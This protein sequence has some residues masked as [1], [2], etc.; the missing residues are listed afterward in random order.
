MELQSHQFRPE[1]EIALPDGT[2]VRSILTE[3]PDG[4]LEARLSRTHGKRVLYGSSLPPGNRGDV[5]AHA[6]ELFARMCVEDLGRLG[7]KLEKDEGTKTTRTPGAGN[8]RRI[9]AAAVF[10]AIATILGSLSTVESAA[11]HE[12][13]TQSE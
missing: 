1:R 5:S 7:I 3:T 8:K 13:S 4:G 10:A 12:T 11:S 2:L 6:D 9:I